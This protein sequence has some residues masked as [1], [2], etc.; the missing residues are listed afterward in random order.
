MSPNNISRKLLRCLLAA[1][2]L[3]TGFTACRPA[4]GDAASTDKSSRAKTP[5]VA[6]TR[7]MRENLSREIV[8]D[9]EFRPFQD[10]DLHAHVAGFVQQMNADVGDRVT[11]GQLIAAIEIPEFKEELE[12]AQAVKHRT[13]E[14]VKRSEEDARR[15]ELDIARADAGLKR[16]DAAYA[17]AHLTYD[18]FVA[19]S[20]TQ[21]G[22]I[23]QQELDV[24]QSRERT[25]AA[26]VDEARAVQASAR[27][28]FSA[29]KATIL[30]V[31]DGVLVANAD[32][33]RL[34]AKLAYTRITAPFAGVVTKRFSDV[35]DLVRGGLAPSGPAVP[36]VRLVSVDKL[37]LVF[38]LSA[39]YVARVKPGQT[40]EIRIPTLNRTLPGVVA[41]IAGEVEMATRSMEAQIDVTNADNA[42]IP[43]MFGTVVVQLDH[44]EKTLVVPLSAVSR[45][46]KP[47]VLIVNNDGLL[48]ERAVKLGLDT[49]AKIEI[50]SGVK[51]GESVFVGSRSQAKP[52]QKVEAKIVEILTAE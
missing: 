39:S 31:R 38:S 35:G 44:R 13:E 10:I 28:G 26:A 32:I 9:A 48:E 36:I 52:G 47:N 3:A 29:A 34:E 11:N 46:G 37:R 6:V 24:S 40:V 12:R 25:A 14:D 5:I 33:H 43:G 51:E 19:V 2:G 18:R 49:A 30:A 50:L 41:R 7:V 27:A 4:D 21:P 45:L 42:I 23:A 1:A 22:L 16:A 15:A 20:K 8:F 17:E